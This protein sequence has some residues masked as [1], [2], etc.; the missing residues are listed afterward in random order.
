M[1]MKT[2]ADSKDVAECSHDDKPTIGMLGFFLIYKFHRKMAPTFVHHY[3][4][5]FQNFHGVIQGC[6][7][8]FVNTY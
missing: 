3:L 8:A 2:E 7:I 6:T 4:C 5:N 1:E